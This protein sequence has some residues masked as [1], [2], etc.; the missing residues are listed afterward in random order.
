MGANLS[1]LQ[2][3]ADVITTCQLDCADP[4]PRDPSSFPPFVP[5][6]TG[7]GGGGPGNSISL[8]AKTVAVTARQRGGAVSH[9]DA[10]NLFGMS[11]AAATHGALANITGRRPF[12]LSR[13]GRGR[14]V[15]GG[16]GR[17]RRG[18]ARFQSQGQLVP[19]AQTAA[20]PYQP[21]PGSA[22][23][24][25][26]SPTPPPTFTHP[27]LGPHSPA[28]AAPPPTGAAAARQ[29]GATRARPSPH[30]P[31][32][33]PPT[34]PRST[35][36]GSGRFTAHWTGD[37]AAD[38]D[39]LRWSVPGL[40]NANL[41]G[42]PLAGSD[43]CG[44]K[45]D[46]NPEL[47]A[48]WVLGVVPGACGRTRAAF[49]PGARPRLRRPHPEAWPTSPSCHCSGPA[50]LP[51]PQVDCRR[52]V[53]HL[54]AQPQRRAPAAG[55]GRQGLGAGQQGPPV[56]SC[57]RRY[58]SPGLFPHMAFTWPS[59]TPPPC[60]RTAARRAAGA[61]PLALCC[62]NG[63]RRA[64][65]ALPPAALSLFIPRRRLGVGW[66]RRQAPLLC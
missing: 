5:G 24:P 1:L 30:P 27:P 47:C 55:G 3:Y 7:G 6:N 2:A 50:P 32:P 37:N 39:N 56:R 52:R 44:F 25:A 16:G 64:V 51:P 26:L 60:P 46:T 42:M 41:W 29:I 53:L 34:P 13:C 23:L 19:A 63:A 58:P 36:P 35:F 33:H 65:R 18:R 62:I 54:C 48:R 66:L 20:R 12:L 11:E 45:G 59:P 9:Y 8:W 38:W 4:P 17:S 21:S 57:S 28:P 22:P 10:H 14:S 43:I 61:I 49:P 15:W 31:P 40:L